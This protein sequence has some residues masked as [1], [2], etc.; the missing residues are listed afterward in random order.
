MKKS[1]VFAVILFLSS[2]ASCTHQARLRSVHIDMLSAATQRELDTRYSIKQ[3]IESSAPG[4]KCV[5]Y[6]NSKRILEN[7]RGIAPMRWWVIA[8]TRHYLYIA[9]EHPPEETIAWIYDPATSECRQVDRIARQDMIKMMD[10]KDSRFRSEAHGINNEN[11]GLH[12][13]ITA[14]TGAKGISKACS[15]SY[16]V[17]ISSGRILKRYPVKLVVQRIP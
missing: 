7:P 8:A 3:V 13:S 5:L 14:Q 12:L 6:A 2:V 11:G 4:E 1:V 15:T 10:S 17:C 16:D 9:N